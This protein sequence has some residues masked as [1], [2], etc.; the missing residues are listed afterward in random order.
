M[1]YVTVNNKLISSFGILLINIVI[2]NIRKKQKSQESYQI[3]KE[4]AYHEKR[5]I[6]KFR[7]LL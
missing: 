3:T 4:H 5:T 2:Q 1:V 6:E 7:I